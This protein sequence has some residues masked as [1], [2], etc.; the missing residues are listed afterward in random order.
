MKKA[1]FELET[2][3]CPS[4]IKKIEAT[5]KREKGVEHVNVLFNSNKVRATYDENMT[6]AER[7]RECIADIGYP[8][9]STKTS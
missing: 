6:K 2:L 1:V 3:T 8:V 4:C 5:L 7:L 9:L